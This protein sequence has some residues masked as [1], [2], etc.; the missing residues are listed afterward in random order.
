MIARQTK[1]WISFHQE[2]QEPV[3]DFE[4]I[5]TAVRE[6]EEQESA[7]DAFFTRRGLTSHVVVYEEMLAD[8]AR[9]VAEVC[10]HLGV[11]VPTSLPEPRTV[12]QATARNVEWRD[13]YRE[14]SRTP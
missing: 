3:Y 13:R 9:T 10:G 4:A 1:C 8:P 5:E 14:E 7:W 2:K 6:L 12:R 11:P